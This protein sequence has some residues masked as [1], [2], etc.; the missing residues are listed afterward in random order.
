[1]RAKIRA[2]MTVLLFL[3][4]GSAGAQFQY[5]PP[6]G[7]EEK[8]ANRREALEREVSQ[9]RYHLGPVRIAPWAALHDIAYVRTLFAS[10]NQR[11]P[12][13]FTATAG[14]G[15]RA[16]LHDTPKVTW[17]LGVLP[18]YVWWHRQSERRRLNG[19]YQLGLHG[20]FNR[21]T[22]EATAG[23]E[24]RL[25]IVTPEVPVLASARA[26][27]G[28][29]LAEV[30]VTH[31]VF[32][33]TS[34]A[35]TQQTHLVDTNR[36]PLIQSLT[37][38]NRRE[39]VLRGGLRWQPRPQWSVALGAEGSRA[40]FERTALPR[41][42]S[43]TSPL[44]QIRFRGHDL[45]FDGEVADRSLNARR[46]ADFVPFHK[47]TGSAAVLL[48]TAS[49]LRGSVY[50][51]RNLIYSLATGYAYLQDDRVGMSLIVD[52]G[53]HTGGRVFAETGRNEYTAFAPGIP[54]RDD[55]V[56]SLGGQFNFDLGGQTVLGL[57]FLRSRFNSNLPGG[58][59]TF[60]SAGLTLNVF[61]GR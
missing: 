21:L 43:G 46:G 17:S 47:V 34:F 49:R 3:M 10:D 20:F 16:Y 42:N 2:S 35:A 39:R 29:V 53:F 8:P 60:S 24:Q 36:D 19:R 13:D 6:G 4:A 41:S 55:N 57:Q 28:E 38:L 61:A 51:S 58:D 14:A 45:S 23:R 25:Q 59:R 22:L 31:A 32:A 26:D 30:E 12:T 44:L 50:G 7:P 48:G 37:L 1:M 33:F 5:T 9:A 52:L 54:R 56:S 40:D 11:S 27:G 15:F 18:E